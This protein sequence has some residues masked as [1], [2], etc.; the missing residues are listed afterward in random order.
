MR[1]A[2]AL[3][4]ESVAAATSGTTPIDG[5]VGPGGRRGVV[6]HRVVGITR[7]EHVRDPVTARNSGDG[8]S[9]QERHAE[10]EYAEATAG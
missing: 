6:T 1:L 3:V 9:G 8:Q 4:G 7:R 2:G 10:Q 5:V